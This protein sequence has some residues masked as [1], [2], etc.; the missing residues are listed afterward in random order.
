MTVKCNYSTI[1]L[2][3]LLTYLAKAEQNGGSGRA[4]QKCPGHTGVCEAVLYL[5][6]ASSQGSSV[7]GEAKAKQCVERRWMLSYREL[8][9]LFFFFDFFLFFLLTSVLR[10]KA[11]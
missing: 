6:L 5:Y 9:F 1:N 3:H 8:F 7:S 4:F 10:S 11:F 2:Y